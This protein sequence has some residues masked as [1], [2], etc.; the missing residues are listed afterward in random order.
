MKYGSD[1]RESTQISRLWR[2]IMSRIGIQPIQIPEEVEIKIENGTVTVSGPQGEVPISLRS[3]VG[4]NIE[5]GELLV[6]RKSTSRFARALHGTVRA[7]LANA[8]KGVQDKYEKRLVLEGLGYRAKKQGD[9]LILEIGFSHPVHIS[10][11]EG[12]EI[13]VEGKSEVSVKGVDKAK[14]GKFAAEVRAKRPPE[15]YQGKGIRYKGEEI[16]KKPGKAAKMGEGFGA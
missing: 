7:L 5:N 13:S 12:L 11:P 8:V 14:V 6:V 9:E 2:I 3:E 1:K 15:P 10:I 4:V 16:K